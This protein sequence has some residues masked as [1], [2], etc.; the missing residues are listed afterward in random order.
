MLMRAIFLLLLKFHH[1]IECPRSVNSHL[2]SYTYPGLLGFKRDVIF[3][4]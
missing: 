1:I 4:V 2:K 3:Q